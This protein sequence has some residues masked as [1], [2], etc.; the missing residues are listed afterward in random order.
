MRPSRSE[1][2]VHLGLVAKDFLEGSLTQTSDSELVI[3]IFGFLSSL[4]PNTNLYTNLIRFLNAE[5]ATS[6]PRWMSIFLIFIFFIHIFVLVL[7]LITLSFHLRTGDYWFFKIRK[8]LIKLDRTLCEC[9]GLGFYALVSIA[10]IGAQLYTDYYQTPTPTR[11]LLFWFRWPIVAYSLW[12]IM[13]LCISNHIQRIWDPTG[14]NLLRS[15]PHGIPNALVILLNSSFGFFTIA[16]LLVQPLMGI[17]SHLIYTRIFK[18][19][20]HVTDRLLIASKDPYPNQFSF[21]SLEKILHPL[22]SI[23]HLNDELA[24]EVRKS[25]LFLEVMNLCLIMTYIPFVYLTYRQLFSFKQTENDLLEVEEVMLRKKYYTSELKK[26]LLEAI[27][28]LLMLISYQP[29]FIWMLTTRSSKGLLLSSAT[30]LV[31]ELTLT[32]MACFVTPLRVLIRKRTEEEEEESMRQKNRIGDNPNHIE[33]S[34][35]LKEIQPSYLV[36]SSNNRNDSESE[37]DAL[38]RNQVEKL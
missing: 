5:A 30:S 18:T 25:A 4:P 16:F 12:C 13:W 24:Y 6:N 26:L 31:P 1:T 21:S 29:L 28:L 27:L 35:Q 2:N 8:K 11:I 32:L 15:S 36:K 38:E 23:P 7:A 20:R 3:K 14:L 10:E 19:L 34:I 9:V 22:L 17:P 33:H 37:S